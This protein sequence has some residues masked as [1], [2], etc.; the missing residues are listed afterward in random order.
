MFSEHYQHLAILQT[1][2]QKKIVHPT[3][4]KQDEQ[5]RLLSMGHIPFSPFLPPSRL[6][7]AVQLTRERTQVKKGFSSDFPTRTPPP[8]SDIPMFA[9][10]TT[11][12]S[13]MRVEDFRW[14]NQPEESTWTLTASGLFPY[15]YSQCREQKKRQ[16]VQ[17][18]RNSTQAASFLKMVLFFPPRSSLTVAHLTR[19][20]ELSALWSD[21]R[22]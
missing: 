17:A 4:E 19:C 21:W 9:M 12:A 10:E 18:V 15:K 5:V 2:W 16:L 20:R 3:T 1:T 6:T 8:C 7:L 13:S 11:V 14:A 22:N